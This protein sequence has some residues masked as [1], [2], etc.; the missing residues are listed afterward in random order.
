MKDGKGLKRPSDRFLPSRHPEPGAGQVIAHAE[1]EQ[2]E[3]QKNPA[4]TV[5][6]VSGVL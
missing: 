3:S 5:T 2:D 1:S 4:I 6:F